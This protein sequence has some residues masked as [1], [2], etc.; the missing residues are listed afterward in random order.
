MVCVQFIGLHGPVVALRWS[1]VRLY[2]WKMYILTDISWLTSVPPWTCGDSYLR[3]RSPYS[4]FWRPLTGWLV[5]DVPV[6]VRRQRFLETSGINPPVVRRHGPAERRSE[7]HLRERLQTFRVR[8]YQ[9]TPL[10][11]VTKKGAL[12]KVTVYSVPVLLLPGWH[13]KYVCRQNNG[14]KW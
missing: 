10:N 2:A 5:T 3:A 13:L 1:G 14:R 7:L 12:R 4:G 11:S 6:K 9:L 8:S